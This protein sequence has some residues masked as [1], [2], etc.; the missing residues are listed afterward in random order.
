MRPPLTALSIALLAAAAAGAGAWKAFG[1]SGTPLA[2]FVAAAILTELLAEPGRD[3]TSEPVARE[4]L[5]LPAAVH[6]AAIVVLGPWV[7]ALVAALGGIAGAAG[8]AATLPRGLF[9]SAAVALATA[10]GGIAFELAGGR[11]GDLALLDGLVP[12]LALG[13]TYAT[14]RAVLFDVGVAREIFDPRIGAAAG[15]VAFGTAIALLAIARPWDVVVVIPLAIAVHQTQVRL[16]RVQDET[17][18]ALETF[19][20]IVDERDPST[21]RHS[22]RVAAYVDGLARALRLPFSDIDRLRWAGR[23]HD[24]GKVAVDAAVLRK[25]GRLDR[26]EWAAVRRHPRLSARLLQRFEFVATQAQAVELHHERVDGRG[27]YGVRGE[28][29]PLAAH[30]LI[31]ADAYDAMRTDRPYRPALSVEDAVAEIERNI[32]TQFHPTV[33]KAFVA[34]QRGLRPEHVLEPGELAAIRGA[35]ASYRSAALRGPTMLAARADVLVVAGIVAGLLGLAFAQTWLATAGGALTALAVV[36]RTVQRVRSERLVAAL[37]RS[38]QAPAKDAVFT[39]LVAVLA[40]A[41][42]L[43]WVAL[44]GWEEDGLGGRVERAYGDGGPDL[45]ALVS[46]LVREAESG[47]DLLVAAGPEVGGDGAV[48]ALPLR[49][50]TSALIGFLAVE[51]PRLPPRHVELALRQTLDE[52]GLALADRPP[53]H[54]GAYAVVA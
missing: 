18:R 42:S 15:E 3:R 45:T 17:F 36:I 1:V 47:A 32:G 14:L 49:R 8:G 38:L 26:G 31:V 28:D 22:V 12:V 39:E 34:V 48:V 54:P 46:W 51:A 43:T 23:L 27:Y 13:L 44:V 20:N 37:R 40:R 41:W 33:A 7:A 16:A 21:Y 25:P 9:R 11:T 4:S 30:F 52:L 5:Q 2:L 50:E 10:A 19:A 29:L 53:E 6:V 35:S 24:L